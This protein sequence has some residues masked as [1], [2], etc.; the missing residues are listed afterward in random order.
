MYT[1]NDRIPSSKL[2]RPDS[3]A[4][5]D[6]NIDIHIMSRTAHAA[7]SSNGV[8]QV[9]AQDEG[10]TPFSGEYATFQFDLP[11]YTLLPRREDVTNL[12]VPN[13]P[14]VSHVV[15]A[16][17]RE[18]P[19]LWQLGRAS[20][21]A[22]ALSVLSP[23][24][25]VAVQDLNVTYIQAELKSQGAVIHWPVKALLNSRGSPISPPGVGP[26]VSPPGVA[27]PVSPPRWGGNNQTLV[28]EAQ[29]NM[30][31]TA[32]SPMHPNWTFDYYY[33]WTRNASRYD[34]H[35][36]QYDEVCKGLKY[37]EDGQPCTVLNALDGKLYLLVP[38]HQYCCLCGKVFTIRSDWL[39]DGGTTYVG[40]FKINGRDVYGWLKYGASDNYYFA[41]TDSTREP[42]R[43][44]EHKNGHLKQWDFVTW[45]PTHSDDLTSMLSPPK[46]CTEPCETEVCKIL[47]AV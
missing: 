10:Q 20:G 39:Q 33:D 26:P 41:T 8:G 43:Y 28:W 9:F 4:V 1:Q 14:S 36:G 38:T 31:D 19:T 3:I 27:P 47:K 32:D 18:E 44:M 12:L 22:A 45:K 2:R 34:H 30:T 25:K 29:V 35:Q 46:N 13:C 21:V 7:T 37:Q 16:A 24:T 6:W 42:V 5:A 40:E 23:G 11:Y 17:V 15:F